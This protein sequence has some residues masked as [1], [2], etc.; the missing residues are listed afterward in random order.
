M[1]VLVL[2][3]GAKD[4]A[5][6]WKFS[7]SKRITGLYI[8]PGNAGTNQLGINLPNVDPASAQEVLEA[9]R[10]Y[11]IDYVFCGTEAPLVAGVVDVLSSHGI[12]TFGA[13]KKAVR[14]E[15]DRSFARDFTT[16]YQI[17]IPEHSIVSDEKELGDFLDKNPGKRF[18]IKKNGLAPSR[19][20]LDSDDRQA[21]M[22][23]GSSLLSG[24]E[25]LIEE[26]LKGMPVTLT[27]FTDG[28][29]YLLLPL[30]SD[31][32]KAEEHDKGAATGGMGSICP[33]PVMNRE[34]KTR[35]IDDIVIP[36]LLGMGE[37]DL[38]YKG[39]LIFSLILTSSGPRLV[40]YHVR[41][42]DPA[43]QALMPLIRSDL[44]DM[45]EALESRR[46]GEFDLKISNQS[47]VAV[48]VAS[49]G[50]PEHPDTGKLVKVPSLACST[51][52]LDKTIVFYGAVDQKEGS[53][54]TDGGRC[55]TV[56]GLGTNIIEANAAAYTLAPQLRF[57]GA[58]YRS[59]IGN[60][61]FDE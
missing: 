50:Y 56:V 47:A 25:I 51:T 1:K 6:T 14:L 5:I 60:R 52:I 37:E 15:G 29:H 57:D 28:E 19:V 22:Q 42:N 17:P 58:W 39:V 30:S 27:V 48:V 44:V 33:V 3:S 18:V 9:C 43:T 38:I 13:T 53:L 24:D 49:E 36:T 2:G 16:R 59:D 12:K 46:I 45:L 55:F 40:D 11:Q 21:L 26:H 23:F 8:A 41:F 34:T 61:F 4:H 35:I 7:K 32:T 31:Y 10:T 20:M 54:Y